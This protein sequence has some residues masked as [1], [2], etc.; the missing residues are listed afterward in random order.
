[1]GVITKEVMTELA[2]ALGPPNSKIREA[3]YRRI[4]R[5][6]IDRASP[7]QIMSEVSSPLSFST[8]VQH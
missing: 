8:A 6:Y 4:T 7:E 5:R 1:M 2:K 3:H